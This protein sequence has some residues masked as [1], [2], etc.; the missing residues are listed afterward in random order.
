[1]TWV[2]I[3]GITN[4]E[5]AEAAVEAGA[6]AIGFVF[7]EKSP[8]NIGLSSARQIVAQ[9]PARTERV[10]VFVSE[11]PERVRTITRD[12]SLTA[13][14]LYNCE[15]SENAL[16]TDEDYKMIPCFRASELSVAPSNSPWRGAYAVLIDS[17][18]P[19][20]P[21]GTGLPFN[22]RECQNVIKSISRFRPVIVA[23]GLTPENVGDAIHVL[24]P[25]GVDV[26]SGVESALGKKDEKK[27]QA[28][29]RAVRQAD[30]TA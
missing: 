23:G 15:A 5:D 12:V 19:S 21:G 10:G 30:R 1:M 20:L 22:W 29:V 14:Q 2:K 3:C 24:K 7:Y 25:W 27:M 4:I 16:Q 9:V 8:R 17:G 13:A 18:T 26:S 28:F 11:R 6:D